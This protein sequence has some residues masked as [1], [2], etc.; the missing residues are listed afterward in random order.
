MRLAFFP[1]ALLLWAGA[2][3]ATDIRFPET[4][5]PAYAFQI[6]DDWVASTDTE[7]N[8]QVQQRINKVLLVLAIGPDAGAS[9]DEFAADMLKAAG[10]DPSERR[11]PATLG[12]RQGYI[13][14][15]VMDNPSDP[16]GLR[17]NIR[18]TLV[19]PDASSIASCALLIDASANDAD[20]AASEAVQNGMRF[21]P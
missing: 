19:K 15:S 6:P 20:I 17:I 10:A 4:G 9:L 3:E 13:Y 18:L 8:M 12:G 7:G 14:Y 2:A 16:S 21:L 5:N 11:E 1:L